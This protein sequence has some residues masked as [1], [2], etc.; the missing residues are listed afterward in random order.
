MQGNHRYV[1]G[2]EPAP[3]RLIAA[4]TGFG[5]QGH[6]RRCIRRLGLWQ[7][8]YVEYRQG[9]ER[10][11]ESD[12]SFLQRALGGSDNCAN[13][14][15]PS[16]STLSSRSGAAPCGPY[17]IDSAVPATAANTVRCDSLSN[18]LRD[19]SSRCVRLRSA[20]SRRVCTRRLTSILR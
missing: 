5:T 15:R 10:Q 14:V 1:L 13:K 12:C 4:G 19:T 6:R 17:S 20:S 3:G 11:T 8:Q 16:C 7:E 18:T 9:G 2:L